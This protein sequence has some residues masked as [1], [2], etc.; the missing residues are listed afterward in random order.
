ML[1]GNIPIPKHALNL[2]GEFNLFTWK[3]KVMHST[4]VLR[5]VV[6]FL[7]SKLNFSQKGRMSDFQ[8]LCKQTE[9]NATPRRARLHFFFQVQVG[10]FTYFS[11]K[12]NIFRFTVHKW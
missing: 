3:M 9:C 5:T 1:L 11:K 8:F 10:L 12:F 2:S 7:I 4:F 6:C